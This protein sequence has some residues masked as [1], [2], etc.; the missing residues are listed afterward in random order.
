MD[1]C[2]LKMSN[3]HDRVLIKSSHGYYIRVQ[4]IFGESLKKNKNLNL[5]KNRL[6]KLLAFTLLPLHQKTTTKKTPPGQVS[7]KYLQP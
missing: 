2:V 1:L 5:R 4:S 6:Y 3:E 7:Y